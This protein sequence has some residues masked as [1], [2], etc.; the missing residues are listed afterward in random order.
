MTHLW[1][2][3]ADM[4]AVERDGQLVLVRGSGASVFDA[5]DAEYLDLTAGLWF[6]N[7]GHGRAEIA[8]A[9]GAQAGRLAA[10]S[11]FGDMANEPVLALADRLAAI[12]P[13]PDSKVFFTSG[14]SDAVDTA[15]KL[16]RR[17]W[18][19]VGQPQRTTIIT[20]ERAYHGMHW[21]GTAMGGI[22][23]NR[24]GYGEWGADVVHVGWDS[25]AELEQ[26]DRRTRRRDHRCVLLRAGDGCGRRPLRRR[27]VSAEGACALSGAWRAVGQ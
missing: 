8:D 18:T 14:G 7:V 27:G 20:R 9:M 17:Y 16:V 13:V 2:P 15:A 24:A 1:H 4:S 10:Y 26:V 23:P 5:H 22:E 19:L 21:G 6:A 12:A 3:F 11:T 25:V